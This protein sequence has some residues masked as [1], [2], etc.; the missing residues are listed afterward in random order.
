MMCCPQSPALLILSLL[1]MTR[2]TVQDAM[3]VRVN[4]VITILKFECHL[5]KSYDEVCPYAIY[6]VLRIRSY[7]SL[8]VLSFLET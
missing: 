5:F 2:V 7:G 6:F 3:S 8:T 1:V 4:I